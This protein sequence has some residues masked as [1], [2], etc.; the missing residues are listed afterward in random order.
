[1][2]A[3]TLPRRV[4]DVQPSPTSSER[5]VAELACERSHQRSHEGPQVFSAHCGE[6]R[7]NGV[8]SQEIH[9][10]QF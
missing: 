7:Q 2:H 9:G 10:S 5:L 4:V 1:M 8:R 6:A 3:G